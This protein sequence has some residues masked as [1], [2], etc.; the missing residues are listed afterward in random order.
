MMKNKY[1]ILALLGVLIASCKENVALEYENDPALYFVN[2]QYVQ[3]DSIN[4]S[5]FFIPGNEPDTHSF[6]CV[7]FRLMFV[8]HYFAI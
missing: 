5:F 2:E 3:R 8:V 1:I 6:L 4:H 7:L